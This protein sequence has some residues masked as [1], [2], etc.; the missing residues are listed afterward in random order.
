[1]QPAKLFQIMISKSGHHICTQAVVI[2]VS[3]IYT[4]VGLYDTQI[5]NG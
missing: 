5:L 4:T 3:L 1:M 2:R